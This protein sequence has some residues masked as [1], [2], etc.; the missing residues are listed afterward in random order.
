MWRIS[1]DL[2]KNLCHLCWSSLLLSWLTS[3]LTCFK[4]SWEQFLLLIISVYH[5]ELLVLFQ[6]SMFGTMIMAVEA[7]ISASAVAHIYGK[8]P[9]QE[10]DYLSVNGREYSRHT[11]IGDGVSTEILRTFSLCVSR[12][13]PEVVRALRISVPLSTLELALVKLTFLLHYST[14]FLS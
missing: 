4:P 11:F 14:W 1:I 9:L 12:A 7:W 6:V 10:D 13:L 2:F 5:F 8:D 3:N